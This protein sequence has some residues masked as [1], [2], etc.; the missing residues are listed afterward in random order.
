MEPTI[1]DTR[2]SGCASVLILLAAQARGD[3][4]ANRQVIVWTDDLG[5]PEELP[6]WCR[7]T[8]HRYIGVISDH[9]DQHVLIMH[10]KDNS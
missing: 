7:M 5:A 8:G 10:P 6:A 1:L 9:P 3:V 2:G 4:S